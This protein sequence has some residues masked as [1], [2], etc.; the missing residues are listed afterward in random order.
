VRGLGMAGALTAALVVA[1]VAAANGGGNLVAAPTV[2]IGQQEFGSTT[3]GYYRGSAAAD[4]WK[5]PLIA[6]DKVTID[7][8]SN[9]ANACSETAEDLYVWPIGTTDFSI[10]NAS[11]LQTW[12][13]GSNSKQE[14]TFTASDTGLFPLMFRGCGE[15]DYGGGGAY[16][17]TV[18]VKHKL[19]THLAAATTALIARG[20]STGLP[21]RGTLA[22]QVFTGDGKP[23]ADGGVG[24]TLTGYWS[25]AWHP[26]GK[27]VARG[28]TITVRYSLPPS[29]HSPI[30][31]QLNIGGGSYQGV[32]L[33]YV[34]LKA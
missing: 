22:V 11:P 2:T 27:S 26:L 1:A 10:N 31:L 17:F 28:G 12:S 6:A 13:V 3:D 19:V 25:A 14:E 7:W 34:G 8:E 4:Y 16:D 33:R 9:N 15:R 32:R 24:G 5:V 29:A 21:R 30:R 18:Y 20:R 23:I